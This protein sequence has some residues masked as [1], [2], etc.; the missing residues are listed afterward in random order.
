[1]FNISKHSW[2][3]NTLSIFEVLRLL[4]ITAATLINSL[5]FL[6]ALSQ[7]GGRSG[8]VSTSVS[9]GSFLIYEQNSLS[10]LCQYC[11]REKRRERSN[12]N[13]VTQF[14]VL[15]P[16]AFL[17]LRRF[18]FSCKVPQYMAADVINTNSTAKDIKILSVTCSPRCLHR[19]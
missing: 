18:F 19:F 13:Y 4:I 1:M 16:K 15:S 8:R 6:S 9:I 10:V 5:L 3:S 7:R 2:T 12:R 17:K 11:I 14:C